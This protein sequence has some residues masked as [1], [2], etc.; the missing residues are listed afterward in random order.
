MNRYTPFT[1]NTF[2][3]SSLRT[4]FVDYLSS[5]HQNTHP[6]I[7]LSNSDVSPIY[8]QLTMFTKATPPVSSAST[9]P[10]KDEIKNYYHDSFYNYLYLLSQY[11]SNDPSIFLLLLLILIDYENVQKEIHEIQTQLNKMKKWCFFTI[12]FVF[13]YTQMI[14]TILFVEFNKQNS[15]HYITHNERQKTRIQRKCY[16]STHEFHADRGV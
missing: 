16:T 2:L 4:Q 8:E 9:L 13:L 15:I 3:S 5:S 6:S 10:N 7:I 14:K 12:C 1:Q 11:Q